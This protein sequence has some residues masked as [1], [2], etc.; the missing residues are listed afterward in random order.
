MADP[1]LIWIRLNIVRTT[2][3]ISRTAPRLSH[4]VRNAQRIPNHRLHRTVAAQ[5]P[6]APRLPVSRGAV[7]PQMSRLPTIRLE[8]GNVAK[9]VITAA[10]ALL[11]ILAALLLSPLV[12]TAL[13]GILIGTPD[14]C[15][16]VFSDSSALGNAFVAADCLVWMF[17]GMAWASHLLPFAC[18]FVWFMLLPLAIF[19]N[20]HV[21]VGLLHLWAF[22][23]SVVFVALCILAA[24]QG[25]GTNYFSRLASLTP[26][27][28][29]FAATASVCTM[30]L[31]GVRG[32][33]LFK[34]EA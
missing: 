34:R 8:I 4:V 20:R 9:R 11:R 28:Y 29:L 3:C 19:L 1:V 22:S 12:G 21:G 27:L 6:V 33:A 25:S 24:F 23:I 13:F 14:S 30:W 16:Y 31:G 10:L 2:L 26:H 7:R 32:N 15:R 17:I 18:I 5:P